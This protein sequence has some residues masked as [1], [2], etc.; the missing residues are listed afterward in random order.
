MKSKISHYNTY[1]YDKIVSRGTNLISSLDW[2]IYDI[3]TNLLLT[4]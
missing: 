2:E 4:C 3:D 1:T